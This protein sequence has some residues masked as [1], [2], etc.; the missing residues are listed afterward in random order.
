MP[1]FLIGALVAASTVACGGDPSGP[2]DPSVAGI[3]A[4]TELR[5]DPQGVLPEVDL[6][7]RVGN[8]PNLVLTRDGEAQLV[9]TDP[10]TGLVTTADGGYSTPQEGARIAFSSG[11]V[12]GQVLLSRRMTFTY[13]DSAGTLHFDGSPPDG[14]SRER[15]IQLVPEW[16][17]EQLIDPV[18]GV[19]TVTFTRTD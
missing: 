13:D 2:S 6:L 14:V 1:R 11:D 3:Y 8:V 10:S 9:F 17:E 5:F 12:V 15:L 4:M 19:L 18:P 16:S 7:D